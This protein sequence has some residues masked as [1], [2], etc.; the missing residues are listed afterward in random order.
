MAEQSQVTYVDEVAIQDNPGTPAPPQVIQAFDN[1]GNPQPI[2]DTELQRQQ[3]F[4]NAFSGKP[5]DVQGSQS[6][7]EVI[8]TADVS[9]L[10][11]KG[12]F[13]EKGFFGDQSLTNQNKAFNN[14][15]NIAAG[16]VGLATTLNRNPPRASTVI[17]SKNTNYFMYE[18]EKELLR[19]RAGEFSAIGIV[20]YDCMEEFLYI[21]CAVDNFKDL[22]YIASVVGI[23]DLADANKVREPILILNIKDLYKVSYLAQGVASI[24]RQF[25]NKYNAAAALDYDSNPYSAIYNAARPGAS[26]SK[27]PSV[28][29]ATALVTDLVKQIA[30][31]TSL[32]SSFSSLSTPGSVIGAVGQLGTLNSQLTNLNSMLQG[33]ST[34]VRLSGVNSMQPILGM[35]SSLQRNVR[36]VSNFSSQLG[37]VSSSVTTSNAK[38]G[39]IKN[40]FAKLS[41]MVAQIS[42]KAGQIMSMLGNISGPGAIGAGA[43]TMLNQLGGFAPSGIMTEQSIGQR[44]PPSVLYKNPML[45]SP[46][47]SGKAFFGESPA[48]QGAVDQ[49]FCKT[50]AAFP[51]A[52]NG[53]G[54]M[55]FGLQNFGSYGGSNPISSIV[56]SVLLG[57]RTP[58]TTG[59]LATA[60]TTATVNLCNILNVPTSSSIEMRRSDNSIPFLSAMSAVIVN[61][62]TM[63]FPPET[64]SEGWK[65]AASTG[66]E[67]QRYNPQYIETCITSL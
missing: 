5:A 59:V 42:T 17:R 11:Q 14:A 13:Q 24:N 67:V 48:P 23:Y 47:Y 28:L 62:T 55:S 51:K 35:I 40:Q 3:N 34:A 53:S 12:Y 43:S 29:I 57:T 25:G 63:P 46:S 32:T 20:P 26:L 9:A 45:Q 2:V 49:M 6:S 22:S 38:L 10:K 39:D 64:H 19:R 54:N 30:L 21:L 58:P 8:V 56:S 36:D 37:G 61:D 15:V 1:D 60:V 7:G 18:N 16:L 27:F 52:Q 50:I 65:L 33:T 66:N 31:S 41:T 4:A 44:I